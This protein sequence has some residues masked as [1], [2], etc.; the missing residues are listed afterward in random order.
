[1]VERIYYVAMSISSLFT[2]IRDYFHSLKF[3]LK[4]FPFGVAIKTPINISYQVKVGNIYKGA[5][6]LE[7]SKSHNRVFIGHQGYS[8]I[9]ENQGLINIERGGKLVVKGTARFA[10]GIRLWIDQDSTIEVGDNFYC[11]K[12]CLFRAFDNITIGKDVL[13]GWNI[14]LN[15]S[16][17]HTIFIDGIH[18]Q[19]HGPIKI[20]NHVWVASHVNISKN[21]L[22]SNNSIISQK[23]LVISKFNESNILIGGIPAKV[24][25]G[26]VDW[27]I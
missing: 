4:V 3:C 19:N 12:N 24:L 18:K 17:G 23:S 16:D 25:K 14:E 9:A 11:N 27:N 2:Q 1:M 15:T 26:N 6:V 5:I 21:A 7:G 22:L 20:G 8:A 13:M 10:Q